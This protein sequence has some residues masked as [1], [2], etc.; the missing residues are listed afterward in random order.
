MQKKKL[1][2]AILADGNYPTADY[3]LG[4]LLNAD[5]VICCD[6]SVLKLKGRTPHYIVGDMDSLPQ[7]YKEKYKNIFADFF[8]LG[9]HF[10]HNTILS[11][12]RVKISQ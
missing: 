11:A 1:D 8:C 5:I 12:Y 3:P 7:E 2:I 4:L 10:I 9:K 6:A